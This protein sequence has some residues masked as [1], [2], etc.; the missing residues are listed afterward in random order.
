MKIFEIIQETSYSVHQEI[1]DFSGGGLP[2]MSGDYFYI[3]DCYTC[4]YL[5]GTKIWCKF[6]YS[7]KE[8]YCKEN[9]I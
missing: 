4:I 6:N 8:F 2:L 3:C 5:L 9:E 7:T 1:E